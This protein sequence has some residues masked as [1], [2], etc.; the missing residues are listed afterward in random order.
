MTTVL[1]RAEPPSSNG[2]A[3][4]ARIDALRPVKPPSQPTKRR[5]GRFAAGAAAGLLGAWL[6]GAM[7][8]SAEQRTDVL[9]VNANVARFATITRDD[10]KIVRIASDT[11]AASVPATRINEIVGRIA[12]TDLPSGSLLTDSALLP[13]GDKLLKPDEA[14]VGVL[15]SAGDSQMI[16]KRGQLVALV[17]RPPQGATGA[18]VEVKGWVFDTSAE[19]V[20]SRERP[21]EV[22]VPR[23]QAAMVSAAGADKRVT[24]VIL[25]E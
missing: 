16:L 22:A 15:L 11:E 8:M 23:D 19:A 6:F 20:S 24:L 1:R 10:L 17:V 25:P 14:V 18:P 3:A 12:A 2:T 13:A 5:W 9:L 7:Y 4:K 21:I